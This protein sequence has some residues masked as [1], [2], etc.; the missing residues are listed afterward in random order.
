M[1]STAG[2]L[3]RRTTYDWVTLGRVLCGEMFFWT[4]PSCF[5][6][7][8]QLRFTNKD[9]GGMEDMYTFCELLSGRECAFGRHIQEKRRAI[10]QLGDY[11]RACL[12][13]GAGEVQ[14]L[15]HWR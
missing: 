10:E 2:V 11:I 1:G 13:S 3:K 15:R 12:S 5:S 9:W 14:R 4:P 7:C 6:I 8:Y